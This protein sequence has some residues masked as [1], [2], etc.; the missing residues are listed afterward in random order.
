[1]FPTDWSR[2]C[3]T[4][5]NRWRFRT[6]L[7][8][9][10]PHSRSRAR[11]STLGYTRLGC[12]ASRIPDQRILYPPHQ[13]HTWASEPSIAVV[14][15]SR[16]EIKKARYKDHYCTVSDLSEV[17]ASK[18]RRDD[19]DIRYIMNSPPCTMQGETKTSLQHTEGKQEILKSYVKLLK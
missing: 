9:N 18:V 4:L 10:T 7:C 11:T 6:H 13:S 3:V 14:H 19:P 12:P 16:P 5:L 15:L 1:M 2:Q 8:R 17:R